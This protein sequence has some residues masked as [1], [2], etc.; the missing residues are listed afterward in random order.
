MIYLINTIIFHGYVRLPLGG[1]PNLVS[2]YQPHTVSP[3]S[4]GYH[5]YKWRFSKSWGYPCV[6][7]AIRIETTMVTW[8]SPILRK[9]H[10]Q[11]DNPY[12]SIFVR[13]FSHMFD[14][15]SRSHLTGCTKIGKL[16]YILTLCICIYIYTYPIYHISVNI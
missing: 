12:V 2:A 7:Q 1:S 15:Y 16:P 3:S 8:G 13:M 14:G 11:M 4:V 5:I 6:I 9:P 10:L